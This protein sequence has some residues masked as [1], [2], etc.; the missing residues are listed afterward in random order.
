MAKR[1][2][3]GSRRRARGAQP[4]LAA[5]RLALQQAQR[6]LGDKDMAAPLVRSALAS[7]ERRLGYQT[8]PRRGKWGGQIHLVAAEN[9]HG[10]CWQLK[11]GKRVLKSGQLEGLDPQQRSILLGVAE[12]FARQRGAVLVVQLPQ[13]L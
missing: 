12:L 1:Q 7:V 4:D 8:K 3:G 11:R 6:A 9:A 13:D 10:R 2:P 5:A